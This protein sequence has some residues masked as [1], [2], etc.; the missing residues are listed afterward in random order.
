MAVMI[1]PHAGL[2]LDETRR[3]LRLARGIGKRDAVTVGCCI[4]KWDDGGGICRSCFVRSGGAYERQKPQRRQS[5]G[6]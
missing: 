4:K 2:D 3:Y 1:G 5:D 6:P